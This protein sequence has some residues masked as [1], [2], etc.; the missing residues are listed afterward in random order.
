MEP[1]HKPPALAVGSLTLILDFVVML[2]RST[3]QDVSVS[4][5]INGIILIYLLPGVKQAFGTA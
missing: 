4:F 1:R 2:G 3:W 5:I